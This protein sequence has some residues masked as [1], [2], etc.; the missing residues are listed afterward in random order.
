MATELVLGQ[1]STKCLFQG[2]N[3]HITMTIEKMVIIDIKEEDILQHI[4]HK[5]ILLMTEGDTKNE[6]I[7]MKKGVHYQERVQ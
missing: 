4:I 1:L 2:T 3:D 5:D 6:D 7:N